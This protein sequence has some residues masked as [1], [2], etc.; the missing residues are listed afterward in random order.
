MPISFSISINNE[1][2]FNWGAHLQPSTFPGLGAKC[3]HPKW[4]AWDAHFLHK[5][6]VSNARVVAAGWNEKRRR[7]VFLKKPWKQ[8]QQN[9]SSRSIHIL[10]NFPNWEVDVALLLFRV[11]LRGGKQSLLP[12]PLSAG[13]EMRLVIAN[14]VSIWVTS[15]WKISQ[16]VSLFLKS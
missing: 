4:N 9:W 14:R 6:I 13:V 15:K 8:K 12:H 7:N 3:T 11:H 1:C 16:L 10:F 5:Q 2:H